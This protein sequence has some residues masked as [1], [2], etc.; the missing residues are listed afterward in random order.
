MRLNTLVR[1]LLVLVTICTVVPG[2]AQTNSRPSPNGLTLEDGTPVK[3]R[4]SRTVSSADA[5][6]GDTVDFEV[7]EEVKVGSLLIIPKGGVAWA[8]V[9]EAEPKRRMARGGKLNMNIDSVRL[10]DGEKVAL[11]AVKEVKG[12]GHTGAMTGGM[13][14]TAIVFFPAAPFFLFMHGKDIS[15]PK[16]T[17][18]TAYINGNFP[19]DVA[20]F[21]NTGQSTQA[22]SAPALS[23]LP[24]AT[25][26]SGSATLEVS[27]SPPGADIEL[28]G[29]F[30]GST[31]SSFGVTAGEHSLRIS[32][33]GFKPWERKLKSSTGTVRVSAELEGTPVP[34]VAAPS[35][36]PVPSN[37]VLQQRGETT[38]A[39]NVADKNTAQPI[40]NPSVVPASA[41]ASAPEVHPAVLTS[42]GTQPP[43]APPAKQVTAGVVQPQ[44]SNESDGTAS[45]TSKPEGATIFIDSIGQG[46][47][48]ALLKLTPGKH[49]LQLVLDGY[50]DWVSDVDIKAGSVVNVTGQLEK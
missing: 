43:T 47:A 45:I 6:V 42:V 24:V 8:T 26:P 33:S 18:I 34:A 21:Q 10:N 5:H 23:S 3:L 36:S 41:P 19:I 27:S 11:R 38:P 39:T 16:G 25:V 29:G 28:D 35:A 48:P 50:K 2:W 30:V 7:L 20:K 44:T 17:E 12:G 1:L 22:S 9:T 32:K 15:I 14:A 40:T 4:I 13:V 49:R 37:P 46:Q 31:P